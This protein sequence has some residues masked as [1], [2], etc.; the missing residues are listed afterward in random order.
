MSAVDATHQYAGPYVAKVESTMEADGIEPLVRT[1]RFASGIAAHSILEMLMGFMMGNSIAGA[2]Y[3]NASSITSNEFQKAS[4]KSFKIKVT[5][6]DGHQTA[7]IDRVYVD[8]PFA[9][10]GEQVKV[11]CVVKPYNHE[12]KL[13]TLSFQ[14]PRDAPD[15]NLVIGVAGGDQID[16]VRHRMGL[17][18]PEPESLK[19]IVDELRKQGRGD[20]INLV[21]GL[22]EQTI[23]MGGV[24]IPDP[25]SHWSKVLFSNRHT[26]GPE[27][28]KA[29]C[30]QA[31]KLTGCSTAATFNG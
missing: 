18:D 16:Y 6:E 5:L 26:R 21:V 30:K 22:P 4:L 15:G 27:I 1:D 10:P 12:A 9:A 31:N 23:L 13:E 20:A 17:S 2:T 7:T 3:R 19:Q 28:S 11:T 25:P 24:K 29:S 14:I 8:K